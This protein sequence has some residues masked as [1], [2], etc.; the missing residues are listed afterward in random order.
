VNNGNPNIVLLGA[1]YA[2]GCAV[3]MTQG[4]VWQSCL[5][6]AAPVLGVVAYGLWQ[7]WKEWRAGLWG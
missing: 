3:A 5:A 2:I 6:I 1:A 7:T 4:Y